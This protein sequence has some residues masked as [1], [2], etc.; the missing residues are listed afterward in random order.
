MGSGEAFLQPAGQNGGE[1][2]LDEQIRRVLER[3]HQ[4]L[5]ASLEAASSVDPEQAANGQKFRNRAG[6]P[7][8]GPPLLIGRRQY[9]R[10]L[11][12]ESAELQRIAPRVS[13]WLSNPENAAIAQDDIEGL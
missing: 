2:S 9:D 5:R 11:P 3:K 4:R 6:I 10:L 13:E 7:I 8:G 1:P 12:R